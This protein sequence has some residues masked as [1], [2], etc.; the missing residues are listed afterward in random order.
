[1]MWKKTVEAS[2]LRGY[3]AVRGFNT[4]KER[5]KEERE[6]TYRYFITRELEMQ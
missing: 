2:A 3:N 5:V 1:M 4:V 6:E